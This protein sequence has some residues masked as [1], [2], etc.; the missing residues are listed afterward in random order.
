MLVCCICGNERHALFCSVG[1]VMSRKSAV[2]G[3]LQIKKNSV[4]L[5]VKRNFTLFYDFF[6]YGRHLKRLLDRCD[7][8]GSTG[9]PTA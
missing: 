9:G 4:V 5:C 7:R 2:D 3:R 1:D 6:I 8:N